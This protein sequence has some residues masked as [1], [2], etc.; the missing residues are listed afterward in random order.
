[1]GWLEIQTMGRYVAYLIQTKI[2]RWAQSMRRYN[3]D[4]IEEHAREA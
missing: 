1:M 4:C 2:L 3:M